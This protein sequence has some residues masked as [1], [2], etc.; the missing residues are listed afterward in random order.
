MLTVREYKAV[1][2]TI[3]LARLEQLGWAW[4]PELLKLT[5]LNWFT[6]M[7]TSA[8]LPYNLARVACY[9][10]IEF[11]LTRDSLTFARAEHF[12]GSGV[13][14]RDMMKEQRQRQFREARIRCPEDKRHLISVTPHTP[15]IRSLLRILEIFPGVAIR[16]NCSGFWIENLE[17]YPILETKQCNRCRRELTVDCFPECIG[18]PGKWEHTCR[19]CLLSPP[20]IRGMP[21]VL[22]HQKGQDKARQGRTRRTVRKGN[23]TK[24]C[25]RK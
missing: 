20:S 5:V 13:L 15:Q 3:V 16:I 19:S 17:R 14:S 1:V 7:I 8:A 24:D 22:L 18:K 23:A 2:A 12:W 11:T 4:M 6:P 25:R 21:D 10:R 9:L